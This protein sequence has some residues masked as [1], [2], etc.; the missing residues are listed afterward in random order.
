MEYGDFVKTIEFRDGSGR[1]LT[2]YNPREE[3]SLMNAY[4][5]LTRAKGLGT[6]EDG[7]YRVYRAFL[8]GIDKERN[9]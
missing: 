2:S 6:L 3:G 7:L 1:V 8:F 5:E 9:S 4:M